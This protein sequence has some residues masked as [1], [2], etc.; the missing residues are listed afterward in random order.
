MPV[1]ILLFFISTTA[2]ADQQQDAI[3]AVM[4]ACYV[5]QGFDQIISDYARHYERLLTD[6]E[7]KL[8]G[9]SYAVIKAVVEQ[10]ITWKWT[11]P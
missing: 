2:W 4:K 8:G 5:Q 7:K 3:E 10:Q 1:V 11:F 9:W 6:D